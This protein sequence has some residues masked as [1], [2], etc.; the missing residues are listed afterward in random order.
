[1]AHHV[2][3][4]GPRGK[5]HGF[6]RGTHDD[7]EREDVNER[8]VRPFDAYGALA[9]LRTRDDVVGERV[10]V[11]GWSNGGS[12]VLNSMGVHNPVL[13]QPTTTSGFRAALA[14]YPGC[15][16][17]SL[18]DARFRAYGPLTVLLAGADEEVSPEICQHVLERAKTAGSAVEFTVFEG[19]SHNFDDPSASRQEI[20]ANHAATVAAKSRAETFFHDMLQR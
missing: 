14:L 1:M 18:F 19:A 6:G 8:T 17:E 7:P 13:D 16:K 5:A 20:E 12:T 9:Y 4:F 10:G 3:S 2:D 11:Q 15:G